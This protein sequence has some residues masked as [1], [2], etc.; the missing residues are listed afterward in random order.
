[1]TPTEYLDAAKEKMGLSSDYELAK[2]LGIPNANLPGM[3]RGERN[4]PLDV[5]FKLAITLEL[6]PA[7]VV[8]DLEA[9]REKNPKRREFWSG[10]IRRAAAVV[11]LACTLALNFSDISGDAAVTL[12]GAVAVSAAALFCLLRASHNLHYVK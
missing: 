10:F 9:Q 12:G 4:I 5:A 6:D 1:M 7:Q 8:A 2:R 11:V 3:R